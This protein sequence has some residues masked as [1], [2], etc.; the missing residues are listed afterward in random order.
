MVG[1][2]GL[3]C[4]LGE[5]LVAAALPGWQVAGEPI[6]TRGVTKLVAALPRYAQQAR[7]VQAMLCIADTDGRCA[8][9]LREQWQPR[10]APRAFLLR[11]AVT[12]AE[13]WVLADREASADFF[14]VA[15]KNVPTRPE[16]EPDAKR[17]VL[18]LA[19]LSKVRTLREEMVSPTDINKPG[20]GYNLHLRR[21]V[22]GAWQPS[23]AARCSDS[24]RR[25]LQRLAGL[26]A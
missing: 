17:T 5:R 20:S 15:L 18:R 1:E 25:A 10:D 9:Q 21:L 4:A 3:C 6:D 26:A 12:E 16:E 14:R 22:T 7:H 8:L 23:H 11:L 24:L 2:D 13:S 19:R